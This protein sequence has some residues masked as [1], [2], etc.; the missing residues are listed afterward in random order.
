VHAAVK[1]KDWFWNNDYN[2]LNGVH[3]H[4]QRYNPFGP[5]NYPDEV[6][7]LR[8][9]AALRDEL[10]HKV[11]SGQTQSLAVTTQRR[12]SSRQWRPLQAAGRQDC[13]GVSV[14]R[15]RGEELTRAGRL[16]GGAVCLG[17]GVPESCEPNAA[18]L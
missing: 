5:Q 17:E 6:R 8:E 7:K 2:I 18:L 9:M 15:C 3:T 12:T 4:G 13:R 14:W 1:D 10:I 11:A 16:Q